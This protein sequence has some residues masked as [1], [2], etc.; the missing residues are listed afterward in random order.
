MYSFALTK[1]R[2]IAQPMYDGSGSDLSSADLMP[3]YTAIQQ[4]MAH[5]GTPADRKERAEHVMKL[6]LRLRFWPLLRERFGAEHSAKLQPAYDALGMTQPK[7][8]SLTRKALRAHIDAVEKAQKEKPEAK[9]YKDLIEKYLQKGILQL[10]DKDAIN[11]DW[12]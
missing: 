12:I 3:V 4:M 9:S 1:W 8:A 10:E 6:V 2:E 7:W 11:P 5:P